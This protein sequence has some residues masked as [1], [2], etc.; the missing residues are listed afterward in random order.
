MSD[1]EYPY[2][3][4][5]VPREEKQSPP[6]DVVLDKELSVDAKFARVGV[7]KRVKPVT[8]LVL[9]PTVDI[10]ELSSLTGTGGGGKG[11]SKAE[12]GERER[13]RVSHLLKNYVKFMY[14]YIFQLS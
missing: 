1:R 4:E 14:M 12:K 11:G 6:S 13:E 10:M 8:H 9:C 7:A 3:E 2:L 5:I